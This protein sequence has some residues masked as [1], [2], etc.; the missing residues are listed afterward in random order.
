MKDS[1]IR[2]RCTE[3]EKRMIEMLALAD[4]YS[5]GVSE[6]ILDLIRK[7]ALN[8]RTARVDAVVYGLTKATLQTVE[9][10]REPV[11]E[12][13]ISEDVISAKAYFDL[14]KKADEVV[15]KT[16]ARPNHYLVLEAEGRRINHPSTM[17]DVTTLE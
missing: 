1:Y 5:N 13:L 15:G 16:A 4:P 9:K 12:V 6:Y 17:A 10:R 8:Y 7:D 2:F 11:G 3:Q 14:M